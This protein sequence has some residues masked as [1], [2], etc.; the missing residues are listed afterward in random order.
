MKNLFTILIVLLLASPTHN[1][2]APAWQ[3]YQR[4]TASWYG[5]TFHGHKTANGEVFDEQKLTAAHPTLPMGTFVKVRNM[6]NNRTVVVRINDRG[7]YSGNRIIDLSKG[8]AAQLGYQHRG[9]ALV[10]ILNKQ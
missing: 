1:G 10:E 9:T 5:G 3:R 7:P 4:G 6:R 2:P 8:A